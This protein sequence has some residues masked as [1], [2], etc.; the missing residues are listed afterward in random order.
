MSIE[1]VSSVQ[2]VERKRVLAPVSASA[3]TPCHRERESPEL[4]VS[5][6]TSRAHGLRGGTPFARYNSEPSCIR[7]IARARARLD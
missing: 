5:R 4:S 6:R 2:T 7:S 3:T 1:F